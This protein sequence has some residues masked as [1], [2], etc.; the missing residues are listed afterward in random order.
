VVFWVADD[1]GS[2][3]TPAKVGMAAVFVFDFVTAMFFLL[4]GTAM[5]DLA[6]ADP[7]RFT[8]RVIISLF[9]SIVFLSLGTPFWMALGFEIMRSNKDEGLGGLG[10]IASAIRDMIVAIFR[11]LA[12]VKGSG[13]VSSQPSAQRPRPEMA[14]GGGNEHQPVYDYSGNGVNQE[15][16]ADRKRRELAAQ[17]RV[18]GNNRPDNNNFR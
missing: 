16:K 11:K 12:G 10:D 1:L 15:S 5:V 6:I 9:M 14:F 18:L 2:L 4:G 7:A 13:R 3:E 8:V 17:G